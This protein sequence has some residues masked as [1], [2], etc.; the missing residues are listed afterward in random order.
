MISGWG[1]QEYMPLQFC[2]LAMIGSAS[3]QC[4]IIICCFFFF[5]PSKIVYSILALLRL[6]P[7][8]LHTPN[9]TSRTSFVCR[10]QT[11]RCTP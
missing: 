8:I 9:L 5:F 10:D 11:L 7:F 1:F 4:Y 3:H 6:P 2:N